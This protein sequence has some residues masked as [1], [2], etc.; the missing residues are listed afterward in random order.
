MKI[1]PVVLILAC[2]VSAPAFTQE[3]SPW[4]QQSTSSVLR[5]AQIQ[6]MGQGPKGLVSTRL[7]I[8]CAKGEGATL[9][10]VYT[11]LDA[12]AAAPFGFDPFEGPDAPASKKRLTTI[13]VLSKSGNLMSRF[14]VSVYF[15]SENSFSFEFSRLSRRVS[16]ATRIVRRITEGAERLIWEVKD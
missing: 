13:Q 1:F 10:L 15:T 9:S 12:K 8:Q 16:E 4:I 14:S 5:T 6:V 11:V 7:Q 3:S 2:L